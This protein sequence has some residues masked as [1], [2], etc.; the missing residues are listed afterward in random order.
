M[1]ILLIASATSRGA[2]AGSRP[3]LVLQI[4]VDQL[5]GDMLPRFEKRFGDDGFRKLLA[6]GVYYADAHYD[7]STTFTAV[8]H[9]T[10]FTGGGPMEHGIAANDWVD[11]TTGKQVYCVEDDRFTILNKSPKPHDGTSPRQ[12]TSTT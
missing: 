1:A 8:G 9:A 10:L 7:Y 3:K 5:R 2:D 12:L 4:T 11:L 6:R